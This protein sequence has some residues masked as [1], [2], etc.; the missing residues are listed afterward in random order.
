MNVDIRRRIRTNLAENA[1]R[2]SVGKSLYQIFHRFLGAHDAWGPCRR[3]NTALYGRRGDL[4]LRL[5][6]ESF[7]AL[8]CGPCRSSGCST[9]RPFAYELALRQQY[10]T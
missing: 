1:A 4:P 2:L 8:L 3:L 9:C 5:R 7:W 6:S 10:S